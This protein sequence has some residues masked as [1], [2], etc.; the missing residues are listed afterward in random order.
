MPEFD[1]VCQQGDQ[2][3]AMDAAGWPDPLPDDWCWSHGRSEPM[4]ADSYR[5]CGECS[6]V[7]QTEA[8]LIADHNRELAEMRERHSDEANAEIRDVTSGEEIWSCP[9]C[10]HDF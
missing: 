10:I 7:F 6:H 2:G 9:H 4:D 1:P 5:A 8:E 3:Y